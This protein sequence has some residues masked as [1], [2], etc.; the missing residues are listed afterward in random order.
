MQEQFI[1]GERL[2]HSVFTEFLFF[3][4]SWAVVSLEQLRYSGFMLLV[5]LGAPGLIHSS[6]SSYTL[7]GISKWKDFVWILVFGYV[8]AT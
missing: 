7:S 1:T 6:M 8:L 5:S 2:V 4:N 3:C